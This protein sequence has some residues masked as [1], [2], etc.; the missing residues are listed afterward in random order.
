MISTYEKYVSFSEELHINYT[1]HFAWM[2]LIFV[3]CICIKQLIYPPCKHDVYILPPHSVNQSFIHTFGT[4]L[5]T[6]VGFDCKWGRN[7]VVYGQ[8]CIHHLI[9]YSYSCGVLIWLPFAI[10]WRVKFSPDTCV[11]FLFL[12]QVKWSTNQAWIFSFHIKLLPAFF[13]GLY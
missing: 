4:F 3:F 5:F 13:C 12:R 1:N 11:F 10:R 8:Q 2:Y 7:T 6:T 9:E